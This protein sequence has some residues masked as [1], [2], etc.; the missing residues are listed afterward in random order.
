M[1]TSFDFSPFFR[2]SVGFDR[3][4]DLLEQASDS[5]DSWP[6]YDIVRTGE[7]SYRI[8]MAVAGFAQDELTLNYQPNLLV[9]SGAKPE[10]GKTDYLYRGIAGGK[11]ERR[12]ELADFV[13]V[14]GAT[15]DNGVLNIELK[16]ELPE[17]MKPR[18]IAISADTAPQAQPK[19][20]E[21]KQAA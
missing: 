18:K 10:D 6:P 20:I 5:F 13:E 15:L 3:V 9:V 21:Q 17:A 11:F 19:Q 8:A 2:S 4:F 7:D 12:F 16:R 14:V 1:R